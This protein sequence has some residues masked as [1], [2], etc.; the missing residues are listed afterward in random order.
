MKGWEKGKPLRQ[1]ASCIV[2]GVSVFPAGISQKSNQFD[3]IFV[4][5]PYIILPGKGRGGGVKA[6]KHGPQISRINKRD[7]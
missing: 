5:L 6:F 2:P 1:H 4:D 7:R 3:H